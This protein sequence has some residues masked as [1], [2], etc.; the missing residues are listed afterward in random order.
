MVDTNHLIVLLLILLC[1]SFIPLNPY[2]DC[3]SLVSQPLS[4][5]G[6]GEKEYG[7]LARLFKRVWLARLDCVY[8]THI[9]R[10][11]SVE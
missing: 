8:T 5:Y 11:L 9:H 10:K 4:F 2:W 3:V 6:R 7:K 1:S